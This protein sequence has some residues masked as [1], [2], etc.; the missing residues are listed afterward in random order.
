M[1]WR[2]TFSK[3]DRNTMAGINAQ[4]STLDQNQVLKVSDRTELRNSDGTI[5]RLGKGAEIELVPFRVMDI[6]EASEPFR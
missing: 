4:S 6:G 2:V 3:Q 1:S 5:V